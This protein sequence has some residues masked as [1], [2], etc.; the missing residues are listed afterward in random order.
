MRALLLLSALTLACARFRSRERASPLPKAMLEV[1]CEPLRRGLA[2]SPTREGSSLPWSSLLKVRHSE[3]VST[4][5]DWR[6]RPQ[7]PQTVSPELD[8]FGHC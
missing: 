5:C 4:T 6:T 2:A 3:R 8:L 7:S 1:S